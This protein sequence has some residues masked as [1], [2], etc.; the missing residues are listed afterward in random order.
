MTSRQVRSSIQVS[1]YHL[2]IIFTSFLTNICNC[3]KCS[4]FLFFHNLKFTNDNTLKVET[5]YNWWKSVSDFKLSLNADVVVFAS[6]R[7]KFRWI[8]DKNNKLASKH[9]YNV[10]SFRRNYDVVLSNTFMYVVTYVSDNCC[11]FTARL[12]AYR[13]GI[14]YAKS[15]CPSFTLVICVKHL[16]LS[17]NFV[18]CSVF[19]LDLIL[20]VDYEDYLMY[21]QTAQVLIA[22]ESTFSNVQTGY[23]LYTKLSTI[24][25][26]YN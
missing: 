21:V 6:E 9:I 23:F 19:C 13:R 22:E 11:N 26:I 12:I 20:I 14:W 1:A 15:A 10:Y 7:N 8:N 17:L 25:Q 24:W 4:P 16:N 2:P 5:I 18:L 3:N